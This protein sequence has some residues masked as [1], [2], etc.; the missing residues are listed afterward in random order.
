VQGLQGRDLGL[1]LGRQK[2]VVVVLH[3][4]VAIVAVFFVFRAGTQGR[5]GDGTAGTQEGLGDGTLLLRRHYLRDV[6]LGVS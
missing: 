2:G 6:A 1:G 4:L 3:K 5:L